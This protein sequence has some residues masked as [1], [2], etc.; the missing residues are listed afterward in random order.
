LSGS[1]ISTAS[2]VID[3][4]VISGGWDATALSDLAHVIFFNGAG[5]APAIVMSLHNESTR[6]AL[7]LEGQ[8][9]AMRMMS[10][11]MSTDAGTLHSGGFNITPGNYT[12]SGTLAADPDAVLFSLTD[13]A[14]EANTLY[15]IAVV[16][17]AAEGVQ[18]VVL[19]DDG[20]SAS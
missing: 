15:L 7:P 10:M 14:F 18:A 9:S 12:V 1:G 16:G 13:V 6:V 8:L 19:A 4:N 20:A 3:L 11:G 17:N 2:E 5:G